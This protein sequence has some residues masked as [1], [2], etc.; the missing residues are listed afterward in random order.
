[1]NV[2]QKVKAGI[3]G[4]MMIVGMSAGSAFSAD[5]ASASVSTVGILPDLESASASK[6]IVKLTC[7][8]ASPAWSGQQQYV[9]SSDLGESGFATLLTA[10]SLQQTVYVRV[11]STSWRSL[12]TLLYLNDTPV[13]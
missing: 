11:A 3:I 6:Y 7:Q 1:M 10:V 5:C 13:Q 8:D 4:A 12:V 9:L 2:Q